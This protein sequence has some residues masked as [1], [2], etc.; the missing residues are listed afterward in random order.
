MYLKKLILNFLFIVFALL[1]P[2]LNFN[3]KIKLIREI[4]IFKS[5]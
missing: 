3:I 2:N 5:I 1:N 4:R